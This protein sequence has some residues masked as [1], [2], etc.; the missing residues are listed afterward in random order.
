MTEK[1]TGVIGSLVAIL[2][3]L[4]ILVY[5]LTG[6]TPFA[7]GQILV[8]VNGFSALVV[9]AIAWWN[10]YQ[11]TKLQAEIAEVKAELIRSKII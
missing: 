7:E 3:S 9:V 10:Q 6:F 5:N 1:M 2:T 11:K 8:I 4:N